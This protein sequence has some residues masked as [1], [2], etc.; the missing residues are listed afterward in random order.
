[1]SPC[2]LVQAMKALVGERP[3]EEIEGILLAWT[4]SF[5]R[6]V[7]DNYRCFY[8]D[9]YAGSCSAVHVSVQRHTRHRDWREREVEQYSCMSRNVRVE[10]ASFMAVL[11]PMSGRKLAKAMPNLAGPWWLGQSDPDPDSAR[12]FKAAFADVFAGAKGREALVFY[13]VQVGN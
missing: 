2:C 11:A 1:M 9:Y 7:M 13:R 6:L 10:A 3:P 12:I 4:K 8:T 5:Q